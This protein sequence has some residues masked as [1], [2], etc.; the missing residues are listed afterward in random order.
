MHRMRE[1]VW[2]DARGYRHRSVCKDGL[3]PSLGVAKDPPDLHR[4]DWEGV[5]KDLNNSL[6]DAGISSWRDL[7]TIDVRALIVAALHRRL[8]A[9]FREVENGI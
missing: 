6:V 3:D 5:I 7:Q 4:I 2:E 8:Q 9:L 1:I